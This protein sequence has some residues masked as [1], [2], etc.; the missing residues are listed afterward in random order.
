MESRALIRRRRFK[1][2][3]IGLGESQ[4]N[5][6]VKNLSAAGAGLEVTTPLYIPDHFTLSVPSDDFKRHCHVVWRKQNCLGVA[7]D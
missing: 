6:I 7:F 1:A 4:I 3:A 2:G 5:C